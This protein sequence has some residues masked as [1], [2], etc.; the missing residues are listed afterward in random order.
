MKLAS[1][2]QKIETVEPNETGERRETL[3]D[4]A[5][6]VSEFRREPRRAHRAAVPKWICGTRAGPLRAEA[7]EQ[8]AAAV[9]EDECGDWIARNAAFVAGRVRK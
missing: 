8:S 2:D 6:R 3:R 1:V 5:Q 7:E 4:D 9:G